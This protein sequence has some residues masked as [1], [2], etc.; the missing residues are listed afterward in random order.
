MPSILNGTINSNLT[1]NESAKNI[2]DSEQRPFV[3]S[4][5]AQIIWSSLFGSM[6]ICA[7]IGNLTV[8]TI[9]LSYR[10]M[11][12]KTNIFLFNL[13]FADLLMATFNAMFNFVFMLNSHWAFGTIYCTVNNFFS[14]LTVSCSVFT[15]TVTSLDR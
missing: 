12:T 6:V 9:I 1:Y 8:I 10:R 3:S 15:I 2:S 7:I 5:Y 13:S 11:R 14:Y 4:I